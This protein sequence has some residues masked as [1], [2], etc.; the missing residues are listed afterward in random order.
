MS[1]ALRWHAA[2][3]AAVLGVGC[4]GAPEDDA[5]FGVSRSALSAYCT[6]N[7]IGKGTKAIE[8]DYLPRVVRC[9]N[10]GAPLEALK[11]QAV[12][13]R[14][15]LYYKLN[16]SGSIADGTSDQV[17]TCG[18]QPSAVHYQAVTETAGQVLRYQGTQ[19]AAFYVA[20]AV[21]STAN[22]VAKA[23]DND[24]SNTEHF[25][26]YNWG[27]S[28][29]GIKQTTLG[30]VN[31]GNHANRGCKSQN[32]ASCLAKKGWGYKDILKFYYGM[33]IELVTA[34]GSCVGTQC[35]CTAGQKQSQACGNCG[36]RTRTCGSNCTWGGWGACGSQGTCAPG[37][38]DTGACGSCGS[39]TRTCT[40]ACAWGSWGSCGGQGVC[41]P[42]ATESGACGKCGTRKRTCAG[43]CAWGAWSG[44]SGEGPCTPGEDQS[45]ACGNCG[46]RARSCTDACKWPAWPECGGQGECPA[47]SVDQQACGDCGL[48]ERTCLADCTYTDFGECAG[49][50]PATHGACPT[51]APGACRSGAWQCLTGVT[52]CVAEASPH[53]EVCDGV[54]NDC[55]GQVDDGELALGS[56]PPPYAATLDAALVP[57][58]L[59]AGQPADLRATFTN[60]GA[61]AWAAGTMW[62]VA[63]GPGGGATSD[64]YTSEWASDA[65]VTRLPQAVPVGSAVSVILPIRAPDTAGQV[66]TEVFRL[67]HDEA[68]LLRCPSPHLSVT[69]PVIPAT[70]DPG[71]LTGGS[72]DATGGGT[73]APDADVSA[74]PSTSG[75]GAGSD[76]PAH[77][78]RR[79]SSSCS[80]G[81]RPGGPGAAWL[82]LAVLLALA[83]RRRLPRPLAP[84]APSRSHAPREALE[85]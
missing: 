33:D 17:Y 21:P 32:G 54:D 38:T 61:Q 74:P 80:A 62:V 81:G 43:G 82:A 25:V 66:I 30:W 57:D 53:P 20:A 71:P 59:V 15:Y 6:V 63:D 68:G 9:E 34:T 40:S 49:V 41:A 28:G 19:V 45:E 29:T 16:S 55:N 83:A 1:R 50:D 31:S 2:V 12:A 26:T 84:A 78:G 73:G 65:L 24:Y 13:A 22:C 48:R 70:E 58:V 3:C 44:C 35:E 46:T 85:P 7:V 18:T 10:G 64:L 47:G 11:A 69:L 39:R 14:S 75:G 36:S 4:A 72:T 23:S 37:A 77:A 51:G 42:G 52:T 76:A 67:A 56:P 60:A 8:T 79:S 5:G 27:K